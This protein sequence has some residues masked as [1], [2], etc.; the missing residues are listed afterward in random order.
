MNLKNRKCYRLK[1][2]DVCAFEPLHMVLN[3][4]FEAHTF[5]TRYIATDLC[6]YVPCVEVEERI[7]EI[8]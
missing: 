5:D 1:I 4:T 8:R 2:V 6:T 7:S 3:I